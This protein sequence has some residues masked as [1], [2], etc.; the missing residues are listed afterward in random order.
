MVGNN[1]QGFTLIELLVVIAIIGILSTIGLVALNGARAKARDTQRLHDIRQYALAMLFYADSA[2]TYIPTATDCRPDR[3]INECSDVAA[4]FG[5]GTALPKDPVASAAPVARPA[6]MAS[7]LGCNNGG[8]STFSNTDCKLYYK[9][10]GQNSCLTGGTEGTCD[11]VPYFIAYAGTT[12]T[13][14]DSDGFRLGVYFEY[15]IT[16]GPR[17]FQLLR[18]DGTWQR[19][20]N[21]GTC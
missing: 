6:Y 16:N 9:W 7:A 14:T 20:D 5:N 11:P 13:G 19:C 18:E 17:G 12:D 1:K 15:G 21:Y 2:N 3:P 4:F 8:V 10:M